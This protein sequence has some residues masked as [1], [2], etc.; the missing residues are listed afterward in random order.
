MTGLVFGGL[1]PPL[2][3]QLYFFQHII[4][5]SQLNLRRLISERLVRSFLM[6]LSN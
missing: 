5:H 2:V 1:R 6:E 4:L 3:S